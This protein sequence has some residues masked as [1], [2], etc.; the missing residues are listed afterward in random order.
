ME[1]KNEYEGGHKGLHYVCVCDEKQFS[2]ET[3][4]KDE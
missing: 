3:F 4:H 1:N 2:K